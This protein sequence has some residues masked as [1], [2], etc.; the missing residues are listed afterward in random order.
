MF[1][2]LHYILDRTIKTG[3]LDVVDAGGRS[4]GFGDHGGNR[5]ML[6]IADRRKEWELGLR[7]TLAVG[8]AYMDGRLVIEQGTIYDFFELLA[9]NLQTWDWPRWM[10][11][12]RSPPSRTEGS[13][14]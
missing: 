7:P 14:R 10:R 3:H 8:E 11:A 9:A 5:V 12:E 2:P 6:R 4:Y 1:R 13:T